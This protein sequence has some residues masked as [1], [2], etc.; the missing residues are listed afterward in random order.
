M[1]LDRGYDATAIGLLI[2][3]ASTSQ[4]C[5]RLAIPW[6]LGRWPDRNLI[7]L[8]CASTVA[9][10]GLM[11]TSSELIWFVL[12]QLM[13]GAG[14]ATFW[15]SSQAHAVRSSDAPLR[16]MVDI[17]A[18]SNAGTLAGPALAGA[19]AMSSP[20]WAVAGALLCSVVATIGTIGLTYLTPY[21]RT[22]SGRATNLI[23][24]NGIALGCWGSLVGGAWWSMTASYLPV[25][26]FGIGIAPAGV[27]ALISGAE[28]GGL[29]A[30]LSLR[31][32]SPGR[33][34]VLV[35]IGSVG[36]LTSLVGTAL[37]VGALQTPLI[38]VVILI[39][40]GGTCNGVITSLGPAA[41]SLASTTNEQGDVLALTGTVRSGALL[42]AP[43]GVAA[44]LPLVALPVALTFL[45][46]ALLIPGLWAAD[47]VRVTQSS[48]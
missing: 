5:T 32:L 1:I 45:G 25:L 37:A 26:L 48:S 22:G 41:A 29:L 11:L 34:R 6:M 21:D 15:T 47:R 39:L 28:A 33:V 9:G 7:R 18:A 35:W 8:A 24:R 40:I 4:L 38:P 44:A 27:G 30:L 31:R 19:L 16:R 3:V 2:S 12:A 23:R 36:A 10:F 20:Q 14:R 42:A 17:S 43:L 46:L 13:L